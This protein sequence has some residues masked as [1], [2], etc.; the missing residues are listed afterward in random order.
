[1]VQLGK[2]ALS[3]DLALIKNNDAIGNGLSEAKVV[4]GKNQ[5]AALANNGG[6]KFGYLFFTGRIKVSG[7]VI[8]YNNRWLM[9][10]GGHEGDFLVQGRPVALEQ[11]V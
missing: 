8:E 7:W 9:N 4:S 3:Y 11:G 1:M 10:Q 5:R 6:K 2:G